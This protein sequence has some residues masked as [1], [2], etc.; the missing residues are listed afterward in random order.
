M[1]LKQVMQNRQ[2]GLHIGT[3]AGEI[4]RNR[5]FVTAETGLDVFQKATTY[6][7]RISGLWSPKRE[8][9]SG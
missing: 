5:I 6:P 8:Q 1:H 3:C 7:F 2:K 4:S 9:L